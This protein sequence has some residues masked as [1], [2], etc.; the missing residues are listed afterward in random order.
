MYGARVNFADDPADKV[1]TLATVGNFK[2]KLI[3]ETWVSQK[4]EDLWFKRSKERPGLR[5]VFSVWHLG[6]NEKVWPKA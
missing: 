5:G 3:F 6:K 2:H 4:I 1:G